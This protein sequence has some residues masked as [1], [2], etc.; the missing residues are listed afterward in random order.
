MVKLILCA[1]R[2]I[3]PTSPTKMAGTGSILV[4]EAREKTRGASATFA[5]V[6]LVSHPAPVLLHA[7]HSRKDGRPG[8]T[9]AFSA[10]ALLR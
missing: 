6:I 1:H 4:C 5:P 10:L 8:M 7:Q 3:E 2:L 9:C